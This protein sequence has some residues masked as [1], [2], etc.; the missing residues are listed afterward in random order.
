MTVGQLVYQ[1]RA[2][3]LSPEE[4]AQDMGLPLPQVR[5]ALTYYETHQDLIESEVAE[6][7]QELLFKDVEF[8]LDFDPDDEQAMCQIIKK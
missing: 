2:N 1:M 3:Q 7:K 5:E 4:V 8:E 6:E